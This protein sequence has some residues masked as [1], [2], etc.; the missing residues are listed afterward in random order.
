MNVEAIAREVGTQNCAMRSGSMTRQ[1]RLSAQE[2]VLPLVGTVSAIA[3]IIGCFWFFV[4]YLSQPTT[5]PNPGLAAYTSPVGTRLI[6]LPRESDAPELAEV[7][8][9]LPSPR[10][11]MAQASFSSV[12]Q[13]QPRQT[14]LKAPPQV[15]RHHHATSRDAERQI[16]GFAQQW[17]DG[18]MVSTRAPSGPHLTG[19]PKSWF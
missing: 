14:E 7:Q 16:A 17:S 13:A 3:A 2:S 15:R 10:S 1:P 5:F 4:L 9:E 18:N 11:A 8:E 19:G 12:T 6:P